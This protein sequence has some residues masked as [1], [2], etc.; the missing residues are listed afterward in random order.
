M[1]ACGQ[2][3]LCHQLNG[4]LYWMRHL[5]C[6][7]NTS[8][9]HGHTFCK[10]AALCV[11]CQH[12]PSACTVSNG[13]KPVRTKLHRHKLFCWHKHGPL[14][15]GEVTVYSATELCLGS[16]PV[17]GNLE[18]DVGG[19][20]VNHREGA[21]PEVVAQPGHQ[22]ELEEACDAG[23]VDEG[24]EGYRHEGVDCCQAN[25]NLHPSQPLSYYLYYR[26]YSYWRRLVSH[27]TVSMAHALLPHT[28]GGKTPAGALSQQRVRWHFYAGPSTRLTVLP[29][30]C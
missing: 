10:H 11:Q 18:G 27:G 29:L 7:V 21:H 8:H 17:L 23:E 24:R 19:C 5:G 2:I 22:P 16:V 13:C 25:L 26:Y 12:K 14:P 1:Y 15:L 4:S 28:T 20:V 6:S 30:C 9:K 3:S